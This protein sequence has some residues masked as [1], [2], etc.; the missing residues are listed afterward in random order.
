MR[1]PALFLFLALLLWHNQAVA[2]FQC[3]GPRLLKLSNPRIENQYIIKPDAQTKK[4]RYLIR[5]R[6]GYS[7]FEYDIKTRQGRIFA[8]GPEN[9]LEGIN[10]DVYL[11]KEMGDLQSLLQSNFK[12]GDTFLNSN[13]EKD[14]ITDD[15]RAQLMSENCHAISTSSPK[16]FGALTDEEIQNCSQALKKIA[17]IEQCE[18]GACE[19]EY[20]SLY[21]DNGKP[22]I[23]QTFSFENLFN[24]GDGAIVRRAFASGAAWAWELSV[25]R[26]LISKAPKM[27]VQSMGRALI[28]RYGTSMTRKLIRGGLWGSTVPATII[29]WGI[30]PTLEYFLAEAPQCEGVKLENLNEQTRECLK[31]SGSELQK[32]FKKNIEA[33]LAD[34]EKF[35]QNARLPKNGVLARI[36]CMNFEKTAASIEATLGPLRCEGSLIN[37]AYR[38]FILSKDG[39][40]T[41]NMDSFRAVEYNVWDSSYKKVINR[42][43]GSN[44]QYSDIFEQATIRALS[45]RIRR[46][47]AKC[48]QPLEKYIQPAE[49]DASTIQN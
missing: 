49:A 33:A 1:H 14:K 40:L 23:P 21:D 6:N 30:F 28:A 45:G 4:P 32:Q 38:S 25:V 37:I 27:A 42:Y 41:R 34:P 15:N 13:F 22:R 10:R 11:T 26:F 24:R 44:Y 8:R 35:L 43:D 17:L 3:L 16:L 39:K 29:S 18:K 7:A 31:S 36:A 9:L 5:N 48:H 19:K 2:A 46:M 12:N 47:A 20:D